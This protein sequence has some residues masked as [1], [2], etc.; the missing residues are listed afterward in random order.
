MSQICPFSSAS[1]VS[2][3][4]WSFFRK[5]AHSTRSHVIRWFWFPRHLWSRVLYAN[6]RDSHWL[7]ISKH[8]RIVHYTYARIRSITLS[9]CVMSFPHLLMFCWIWII[10]HRPIKTPFHINVILQHYLLKENPVLFCWNVRNRRSKVIT[11][12]NLAL[13]PVVYVF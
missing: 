8:C 12:C 10:D 9:W 13:N 1:S 3:Q 5:S 4:L 7:R 11:E 6:W 2:C